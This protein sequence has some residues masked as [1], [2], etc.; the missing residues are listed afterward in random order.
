MS[1]VLVIGCGGPG[2]EA[3]RLFSERTDFDSAMVN[4]DAPGS[5]TIDETTGEGD[6]AG[7]LSGYRNVVVMFSPG[8]DSGIVVSEAVCKCAR[9][10]DSKVV[11]IATM[12]YVFE[13]ARREKAYADMELAGRLADVT[14]LMDPQDLVREDES[15][16]AMD[17]LR[18]VPLMLYWSAYAVADMLEKTSF[19]SIFSHRTYSLSYGSEQT[20]VESVKAALSRPLYETEVKGKIVI[21][22]DDEASEGECGELTSTLTD[23]VGVMPE[24]I[25]GHD[26]W[27]HGVTVFLPTTYRRPE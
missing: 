8:G 3:A 16:S 7:A 15:M 6:I 24:L 21:R 5:L 9:S 12:P 19:Y 25:A 18:C 14:F 22:F 2:R 20:V 10:L 1:D 17:T 26:P 4:G 27:G 13:T 11:F 23:R